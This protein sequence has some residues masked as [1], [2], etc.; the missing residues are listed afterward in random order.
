MV[1]DIHVMCVHV[2]TLLIY[3]QKLHLPK[4]VGFYKIITNY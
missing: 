3:E 1:L 2:Y 4:K